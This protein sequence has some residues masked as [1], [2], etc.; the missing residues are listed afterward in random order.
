MRLSERIFELYRRHV[1]PSLAASLRL[2]AMDV[3]ED[4]ALGCEVWDT[5]GRRYLDF[6]GLY[7]TMAVG[8]RH[9][10]VI[11]AV[12]RQ[13]DRMT[14]PARVMLS[15]GTALLA[16]RLAGLTPGDLRY[17]FFGNSG[18]EAVEGAVK[19]ARAATGRRKLVS[20]VNGFHGKTLGALSLTPRAHYQDPFRPLVGDVAHVP[21]GDV[22]A[23]ESTLDAGT[24][25][26]I[27]E[28][29][30]GEGGIVVPP[31]GYLRAARALT[32]ERG[33]VLIA[34][35]VQTGLGRTGR[36]FGVDHDGVEPD[37]MTLAKAL[38]GGVMPIGAFVA[39]P[40]LWTP[41]ERDYKI[42]S[43]TFGGN[44]LACAAALATIDVIEDEGLVENSREQGEYLLGELRA[45]AGEFPYFVREVRGRGLM[46]GLEFADADVGVLFIGE[47]SNHGVLTAYGLN[48]PSM[49]RLE[50]PLTVSR[51]QVNEALGAIRASL[52]SVRVELEKYGLLDAATDEAGVTGEAGAPGELQ[53]RA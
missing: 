6:L 46:A 50:P 14:M 47:M 29:V 10:R 34:D 52:E 41:F 16:E 36:W 7:G 21:Y 31:P 32:R 42:H 12:K 20:A 19:I 13:M 27:L 4:R 35:E 5:D 9:P 53:A 1:N 51:E 24:A 15:E 2:N 49:I 38:G 28:P 17:A 45:V 18:A 33:V 48:Q 8:H 44:P 43:S 26:L 30:Q 40:E 25:A 11:E 39:T 3:V 22:R 23:L 37:M